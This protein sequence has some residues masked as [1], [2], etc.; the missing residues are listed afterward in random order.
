MS[1]A[2]MT[3]ACSDKDDEKRECAEAR[4]VLKCG[5][6]PHAAIIEDGKKCGEYEA[7]DQVWQINGTARDPVNFHGIEGGKNVCGNAAD[8]DCLPRTDN[9]VGESHHP[10][11]GKAYGWREYCGGVSDLARS[12]GHGDDQLA[13]DPADRQQQSPADQE[14]E[15]G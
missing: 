9:E 8:C 7:D 10:A 6:Q 12:V 15:R 14:S 11:C 3:H 2:A 4:P 1:D 5:T 13:V